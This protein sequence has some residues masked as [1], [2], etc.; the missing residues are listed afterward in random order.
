VVNN[1]ASQPR[2]HVTW[3]NSWS[4]SQQR[5][6]GMADISSKKAQRVTAISFGE[7]KALITRVMPK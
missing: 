6:P 4:C 7:K 1:Q 2:F 5:N 3:C